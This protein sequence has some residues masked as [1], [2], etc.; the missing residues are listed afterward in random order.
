[1]SVKPTGKV[2]THPQV[3]SDVSPLG[4]ER[5]TSLLHGVGE[6]PGFTRG[7]SD[8]VAGVRGFM[9]T[10]QEQKS[11]LP[12]QPSL[13]PLRGW[14]V[15][16]CSLVRPTGYSL[17][18]CQRGWRWDHNSFCGVWLEFSRY[19]LKAFCD[20][21]LHPFSWS[22]SYREQVFVGAFFFSVCTCGIL[23]F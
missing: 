5:V 23:R 13:T 20:V 21:K 15:P 10:Q 11:W 2:L 8:A 12:T 14:R 19:C 7:P 1:M 18:L 6:S 9:T 22:F 16:Y 3:S 4:R 17:G